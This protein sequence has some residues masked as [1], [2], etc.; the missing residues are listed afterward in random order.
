MSVDS[1]LKKQTDIAQWVNDHLTRPFSVDK[2]SHLAL[3]CFDLA[4]EHH[5][6]ICA[7]CVSGLYGSMYALLRV[8]FEAYGRGLWL[9]HV[10]SEA[11]VR[12]YG[13]KDK[14]SAEFG[15]LLVL[16]EKEIGLPNG[17]LSALKSKQ[18]EIFCSFTHTGYQ[19]LIRRITETHTGLVN[20]RSEEVVS[21]LRLAGTFVLLSA[22]ELASMAGDQTLIDATLAKAS[23][24]S[25]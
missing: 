24:Y 17:P 16:V 25:N 12:K 3:G 2:K 9:R 7:L 8:E 23:K 14:P 5:A 21:A 10:A 22:N 15:N 1:E 6:A 13:K 11:E 20:Y 4:I 19:A 18:W